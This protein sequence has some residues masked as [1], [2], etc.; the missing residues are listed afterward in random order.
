MTDVRTNWNVAGFA[1]VMD[2]RVKRVHIARDKNGVKNPK[3]QYMLKTLRHQASEIIEAGIRGKDHR[4]MAISML[5]PLRRVRGVQS[6]R[7]KLSGAA[8]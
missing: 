6:Q 2:A 7:R 1:D 8:R 3:A 4:R 5:S